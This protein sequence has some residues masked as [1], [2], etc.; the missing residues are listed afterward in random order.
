M[1]LQPLARRIALMSIHPRWSDAIFAGEKTV[2]LRRRPLAPDIRHVLVYATAPVS[3]LAGWFAVAAIETAEPRGIWHRW[4][5][6]AAVDR[7][8]FDRYFTDTDTAVAIVIGD[9]FPFLDHLPLNEWGGVARPPQ[10][11]QYLALNGETP[12]PQ[13]H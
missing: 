1:A 2:E 3:A 7:A 8:T 9:V 5:S 6:H 13:G 10:C 4:G 11:Y 12:N